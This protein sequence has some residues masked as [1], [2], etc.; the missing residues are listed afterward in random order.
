MNSTNG[1]FLNDKKIKPATYF[2][3]SNRDIFRF[4]TSSREYLVMYLKA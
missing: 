2:D 4:G 1:T 3:L